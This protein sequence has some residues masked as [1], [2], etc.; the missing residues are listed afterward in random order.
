MLGPWPRPV[1]SDGVGAEDDEC[2][3]RLSQQ[4]E[5]HRA[6]RPP[7]FFGA[8]DPRLT[9]SPPEQEKRDVWGAARGGSDDFGRARAVSGTEIRRGGEHTRNHPW[10]G[11]TPRATTRPGAAPSAA[12]PRRTQPPLR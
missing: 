11:P 9:S 2:Q 3:R 5:R 12:P 7:P 4:P 10:R 6:S 1:L 8:I